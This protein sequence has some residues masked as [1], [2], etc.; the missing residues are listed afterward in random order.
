M[1]LHSKLASL[2][3]L[4]LAAGMGA[5]SAVAQ[6]PA[7]AAPAA[8]PAEYVTIRMEI[9]VNKSAADTWAKVGADYCMLSKWIA[10][11]REVPCAVTKGDGGIGSVRSIANGAVIEVLTAK[12]D[13]SYGYTQPAKEGRFYDLYHGFMEA[14]PVT[15]TTSKIVYTLMYDVSNLA[16]QAA[17]DA[18]VKRR[19]TQFEAALAN[20]K[21]MAEG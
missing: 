11:G 12:T 17:K 8:K 16:D 3:A 13:L 2:A 21:K 7:P 18:D 1:K 5:Q 20:M 14:K 9:D 10:A 19:R 15:A 4:A 6:T